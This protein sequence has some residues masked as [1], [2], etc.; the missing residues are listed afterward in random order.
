M[1]GQTRRTLETAL[2][3][4]LVPCEHDPHTREPPGRRARRRRAIRATRRTTRRAAPLRRPTARSRPGC[5][6]CRH[7]SGRRA[8]REV[9]L[10]RDRHEGSGKAHADADGQVKRTTSATLGATARATSEDADEQDRQVIAAARPDSCAEKR[11]RGR[12]EAHAQDGIVASNP[13]TAWVVCR[14]SCISGR[15]GPIPT[16]CGGGA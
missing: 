8:E 1:P 5:R 12:E 13:T 10:H 6:S 7:R 16:I 11:S 9:L 3:G 15:S 14:L 2:V 4:R